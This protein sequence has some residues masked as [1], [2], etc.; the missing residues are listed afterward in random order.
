MK[1]NWFVIP[2]LSLCILSSCAST[3][4]GP[5]VGRGIGSAFK[6]VAH[7]VLSPFQIA[8]GVLEGIATVPY[9]ITQDIHEINKGMIDAQAKVTLD[10]TYET[11][12]GKRIKYVNAKG[13]TG[14]I[15]RRMKHATQKFH[16]ILEQYGVKDAENY[17]LTSIDTAQQYGYTLFAVVKRTPDQI[18][19]IDKYDGKTR[20]IFNKNDRLFYEPF[21]KD[22][23]GYPLDKVID[24]SG[25]PTDSFKTQ[26]GQA[27]LLT[28][29][30]NSVI[31]NKVAGDYWGNEKRWIAGAYR[32]ITEKKMNRV[33]EKMD[34]E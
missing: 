34:V 10:D 15:L 9:L 20:R 28:L 30:A 21:E 23:S 11:A 6:G 5:S 16:S 31:N 26:K 22:I 1:I 24:W 8:A 32:E 14:E 18:E 7:L 27:I 17:L 3:R 4:E 25:M 2:A 12:Y 33:R 29:A 13:D 19:V